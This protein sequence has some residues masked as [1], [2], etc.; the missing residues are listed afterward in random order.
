MFAKESG[1]T[2]QLDTIIFETHRVFP[3]P[4][5][6][7]LYG[8][9]NRE[10]DKINGCAINANQAW[11][12]AMHACAIHLNEDPAWYIARYNVGNGCR[13]GAMMSGSTSEGIPLATERKYPFFQ[14]VFLYPGG[15][16]ERLEEQPDP[17]RV[18]IP[19]GTSIRHVESL[20]HAGITWWC[21]EKASL[22]PIDNTVRECVSDFTQRIASSMEHQ[23]PN[24][25]K[26]IE[27]YRDAVLKQIALVADVFNSR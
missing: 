1:L 14:N 8:V 21:L 10:P 4:Y 23:P 11:T 3:E 18:S 17:W 27:R 12:D 5:Q 15:M 25:R 22:L 7:F 20:L 26:R 13:P 6:D 2:E 19:K 24:E 9:P 16:P